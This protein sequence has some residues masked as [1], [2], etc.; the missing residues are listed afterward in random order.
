M[1]ALIGKGMLINKALWYTKF[2]VH[3]QCHQN[4]KRDMYD[5]HMPTHF[6]SKNMTI[7]RVY[8]SF[9]EIQMTKYLTFPNTGICNSNILNVSTP[10]LLSD[11]VL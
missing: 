11:C 10:L 6:S 4:I 7:L 3:I 5:T 9:G 1:Y 8:S 2:C